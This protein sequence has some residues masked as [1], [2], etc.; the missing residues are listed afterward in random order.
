MILF[1][2]PVPSVPPFDGYTLRVG[3]RS[4]LS[5]GGNTPVGWY[6]PTGNSEPRAKLAFKPVPGGTGIGSWVVQRAACAL[7]G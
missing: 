7:I 5:I 1:Y 2:I 3:F 6:S 4:L